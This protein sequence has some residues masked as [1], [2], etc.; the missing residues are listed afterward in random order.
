MEELEDI[1]SGN[2][3]TSLG[4]STFLT[5]HTQLPDCDNISVLGLWRIHLP[6]NCCMYMQSQ[7]N[8]PKRCSAINLKITQI[9][10]LRGANNSYQWVTK[11]VCQKG[12]TQTYS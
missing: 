11:L 5:A 12:G 9:P 4:I 6:H 10:R 7:T 1:L 2:F 3:G 8:I